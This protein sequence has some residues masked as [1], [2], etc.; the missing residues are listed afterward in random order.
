TTTA[1]SRSPTTSRDKRIIVRCLFIF[2]LSGCSYQFRARKPILFESRKVNSI[3]EIC[4]RHR[5]GQTHASQKRPAALINKRVGCCRF[6]G[7]RRQTDCQA[8]SSSRVCPS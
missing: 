2:C 5:G 7:S 3:N 6:T 1:V 4:K 8:A